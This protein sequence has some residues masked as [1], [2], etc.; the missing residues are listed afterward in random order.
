MACNTIRTRGTET[1]STLETVKIACFA[2]VVCASALT[3]AWL[4]DKPERELLA[5]VQNGERVLH[6][7]FQDGW[8]QIESAKITDFSDGQWYFTNGSAVQCEVRNG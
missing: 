1:M 2:F 5:Q 4:I 7:H 8:R 3:L 6:C